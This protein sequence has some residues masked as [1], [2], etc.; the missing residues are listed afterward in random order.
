MS[1][2]ESKT[3]CFRRLIE[4]R[5]NKAIKM[6]RLIGNCSKENVYEYSP[7]QV[8]QVFD[9]LQDELNQARLKYLLPGK[10][11][12]RFSL[13]KPYCPDSHEAHLPTIYLDLPDGTV[14]RATATAEDSYPSI[15]IHL[16]R[17]GESQDEKICF[18]EYNPN[19]DEGRKLCVGC[20]LE[21]SDEPAFYESYHDDVKGDER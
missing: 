14:L 6:I 21:N 8:S 3:D 20:Y 5:V 2:K 4:A 18:V 19:R 13:S 15:D 11:K 7:E 1:R 16:V 12:K 9:V 17:M 10:T